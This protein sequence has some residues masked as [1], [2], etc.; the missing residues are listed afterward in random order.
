MK[1]AIDLW[2][3]AQGSRAMAWEFQAIDFTRL[4][5]ACLKVLM[6]IKAEL[7]ATYVDPDTVRIT[8]KIS[9]VV[10]LECQSCFEA[11]EHSI[12]ESYSY[13]VRKG[14]HERHKSYLDVSDTG[15][16]E[17]IEL[18]EDELLLS[19]P[20]FPKHEKHCNPFVRDAAAK[21]S[22]PKNPF[23]VLSKLKIH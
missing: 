6:P 10:T 5:S 19:L 23:S 15:E 11:V 3:W 18:F 9:T 2:Q 21:E 12:D 4:S 20:A 8:G 1:L 14:L 16:I 17:L 13:E 22:E 7:L